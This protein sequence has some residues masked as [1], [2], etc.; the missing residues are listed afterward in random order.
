MHVVEAYGEALDAGDKATSKAMSA[1]YK[2]AV[3][4]LFC[5]PLQGSDDADAST[6]RIV[7]SQ[8]LADPDQGWDQWS[9]D[10][11][12]IIGIC[13]TEEAIRRVQ[14]T[15]G[16]LLRAA[17]KRRPDV[18]ALIGDA[19]SARKSSITALVSKPVAAPKKATANA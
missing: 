8:E 3:V 2:Q 12:D 9:L 6:H 10:I 19:I 14:S 4:Q 13:E 1:A 17:S 15:Y 18:F 16:S 5:I 11:R 7:R